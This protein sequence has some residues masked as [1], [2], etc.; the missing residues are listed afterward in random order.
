MRFHHLAAALLLATTSVLAADSTRY[1]LHTVALPGASPAG[2][3]MDYIAY[4]AHTGL[5]WVPAGNTGSVDVIDVKTGDVKQISDFPTGEMGAGNRKRVVG[6]SSVTIAKDAAYIGDRADSSVCA[7]NTR[8][9]AQ[10][11]CHKLD[12]MPDGLAYVQATNEVWVTAPRD[13]TIRIL[14]ATTLDEKAKLTF[15]GNPEGF[16]VDTKRGRFYTNLEDKDLTLAIDLKSHRTVATWKPACGEEGPHGL[17][18]D[19]NTGYLFVACSAK[20]EVMDAGH[21]G[22]VLSS[23]DTGDGVD[24]IDYAP[25][26]HLLYVGAPKDGQLTVA[27]VGAHGK[28]SVVAK[29]PTHAGA[30]NGVVTRDGTVYLAHSA[31]GSLSDI[32]V[33]TPEE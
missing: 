3:Y 30:R 22:A 17:R 2:I 8:T 21:K 19:S 26:T 11:V 14:D 15:D 23:V 4:D 12:S 1:T 7:I 13:K 6:P 25:A 5:V 27:K 10:G 28:L 18:V 29:I 33:V 16:A 24:D 31:L 20:V 32:I 9:F